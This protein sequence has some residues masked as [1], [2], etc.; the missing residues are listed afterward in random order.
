MALNRCPLCVNLTLTRKDVGISVLVL[1]LLHF[2]DGVV[3]L[4]PPLYLRQ[5]LRNTQHERAGKNA[6][7]AVYV[8]YLKKQ[9]NKKTLP[10]YHCD[11]WYLKG[12]L[13]Y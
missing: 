12:A 1:I 3:R 8:P 2:G 13:N 6:T 7:V 11:H 5:K 4:G 10:K 9:T